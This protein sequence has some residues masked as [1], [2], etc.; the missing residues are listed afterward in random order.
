MSPIGYDIRELSGVLF[1]PRT[2]YG[3]GTNGR[4]K[5]YREWTALQGNGAKRFLEMSNP[6]RAAYLAG[7]AQ[8]RIVRDTAF[9]WLQLSLPGGRTDGGWRHCVHTSIW[10]YAKWRFPI[11]TVQYT[12]TVWCLHP[13]TPTS[14]VRLV[15]WCCMRV[16]VY[17]CVCVVC[18][19]GFFFFL[20]E[21]FCFSWREEKNKYKQNKNEPEHW[22]LVNVRLL[23]R[24]SGFF[25]LS[26]TPD[27][28]GCRMN[29]RTYR[30]GNVVF[31]VKY[32]STCI[33]IRPPVLGHN[34]HSARG[35]CNGTDGGVIAN[36]RNDEFPVVERVRP[37]LSMTSVS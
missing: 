12:S 31:S 32:V 8:R 22:Y 10:Y 16:C 4:S 33:V 26:Y 15:Y 23:G 5:T 37:P 25:R 13:I 11:R 21:M 18:L 36:G 20:W 6:I 24:C 34:L 7:K 29:A 1:S 14:D 9:R 27:G 35:F 3:T 28:V 30:K 19:C 17:V 2:P